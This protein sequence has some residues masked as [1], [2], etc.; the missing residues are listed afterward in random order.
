MNRPPLFI[1][2]EAAVDFGDAVFEAQP[3]LTNPAQHVKIF[4]QYIHEIDD[5]DNIR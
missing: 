1:A 3:V 2:G 4:R 5:E